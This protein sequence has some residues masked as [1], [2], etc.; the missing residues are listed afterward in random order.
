MEL[1][2]N[3]FNYGERPSVTMPNP[4]IL[5]VLKEE[6]VRKLVSDHYD[7]LRQSPIKHLFPADDQKFEEAKRFAADFFVQILGGP[8]YFNEN[9][10]RPMLIN[11]H[12]PFTIT[13]EGRRIWLDCYRTALLRLNIPEELIMSYWNYINI[14][15]IWMVNTE[16][17]TESR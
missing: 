8:K 4:T 17:M 2:I 9:R 11:R 6:G 14:F 16:Q 7:L 1:T 5:E 10:G 13:L 12:A 15:S 3:E